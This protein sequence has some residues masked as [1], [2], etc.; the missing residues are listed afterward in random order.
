MHFEKNEPMCT[1]LLKINSKLSDWQKYYQSL[2]KED[3]AFRECSPIR[4][5]EFTKQLANI[6]WMLTLTL[7][8]E[9]QNSR[10]HSA[11]TAKRRLKGS[12]CAL[13]SIV[14]VSMKFCVCVANFLWFEFLK[15]DSLGHEAW[16]CWHWMLIMGWSHQRFP[17]FLTIIEC[18]FTQQLFALLSFRNQTVTGTCHKSKHLHK[19]PN[20]N[21]RLCDW[22]Q[23]NL[24]DNPLNCGSPAII[25][26]SC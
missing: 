23:V 16:A 21:N 5:K 25:Q 14:F 15:E 20:G 18:F 1:K 26:L 22:Q 12:Q 2:T 3:L 13:Q 11:S 19:F 10:M 6:P 9:Q 17:S 7:M 8:Q 4:E 24:C